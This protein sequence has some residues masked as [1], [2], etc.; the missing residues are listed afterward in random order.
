MSDVERHLCVEILRLVSPLGEGVPEVELAAVTAPCVGEPVVID[1]GVGYVGIDA[2]PSHTDT[3][4]D[5]ESAVLV[6]V[7]QM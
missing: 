3:R 2:L 4:L 7:E 6:L 1:S 5:D